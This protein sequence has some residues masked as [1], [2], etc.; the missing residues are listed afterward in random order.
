VNHRSP[1][2]LTAASAPRRAGH[3]R[4][5]VVADRVAYCREN[6][7]RRPRMKPIVSTCEGHSDCGACHGKGCVDL[8]A[9]PDIECAVPG[10]DEGVEIVRVFHDECICGANEGRRTYW[11]HKGDRFFHKSKGQSI[12]ISGFICACHGRMVILPDQMDAFKAFC[13]S[14]ARFKDIAFTKS[15]YT[16]DDEREGLH[17]FTTIVPGKNKDGWWKGEDV[18]SQLEEVVPIFEFLHAASA[19]ALYNFDNST[20]HSCAPPGA[21]GVGSGVNKGPGGVNAPGAMTTNPKIMPGASEEHAIMIPRMRDGWYLDGTGTKVVQSMHDAAGVFKGTEQILIERGRIP[22]E[23]KLP[24]KCKAKAGEERPADMCC[25]RHV[26]LDEP[27]FKSQPS[28]IEELVARLGHF[29]R[30][31]PKCHPELNPIEQFWAA[32]KEWLRRECGYTF[33][34]LRVNV[35]RALRVVSLS[36]VQRYFRKAERF[37]ALYLFEADGDMELPAAVREYAMKKYKRHRTVPTTLLAD[38]ARDLED[39]VGKLSVKVHRGEGTLSSIRLERA[40]ATLA[41]LR[42]V[43]AVA[44]AAPMEVTAP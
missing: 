14:D 19:R 13:Q 12:M 1:A 27:D 21:L 8:G 28:L 38:V 44:G 35:P 25:C 42:Q 5:D 41:E 29:T 22:K 2:S 17:S 33:S 10:V 7:L 40:K 4:A 3:E 26:L 11:G 16:D 31:L 37:E 15:V 18:A 6:R 24:G 39:R 32:V 30:M 34:E 36:Q 20:N 43:P 23:N 9:V